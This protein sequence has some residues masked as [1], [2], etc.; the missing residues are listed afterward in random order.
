MIPNL[1]LNSN[2]IRTNF[3]LDYIYYKLIPIQIYKKLKKI[4]ITKIL[5]KKIHTKYFLFLYIYNLKIIND[6]SDSGE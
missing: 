3:I 4:I 5:Y 1:I 6:V 2:K